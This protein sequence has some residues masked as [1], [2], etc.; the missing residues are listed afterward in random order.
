MLMHRGG[1]LW[2]L[3]SMYKAYLKREF[4]REFGRV[5]ERVFGRVI[6]IDFGKKV[7]WK[8]NGSDLWISN[9]VY[10]L[11]ECFFRLVNSKPNEI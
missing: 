5:T 11:P 9:F 7:T 10:G 8:Y 6:L 2:V 3:P 4:G 1:D